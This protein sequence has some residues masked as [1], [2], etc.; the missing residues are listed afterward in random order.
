MNVN[1]P[2]EEESKGHKRNGSPSLLVACSKTCTKKQCIADQ[3]DP[4]VEIWDDS[5]GKDCPVPVKAE[6]MSRH[7]GVGIGGMSL[8]KCN[9]TPN[10]SL[11]KKA[12]FA[13]ETPKSVSRR[14]M[15]SPGDE[16]WNEAIQVA[17]GL[18]VPADE[19]ILQDKSSCVAPQGARNTSRSDSG[20][21]GAQE[22]VLDD[23]AKPIEKDIEGNEIFSTALKHNEV[24]PLPV[25]HFDFSH[26]VNNV[27]RNSSHYC[28]EEVGAV[29]GAESGLHNGS[30]RHN[31]LQTSSGLV[32][33]VA[34]TKQFSNAKPK[35]DATSL[36]TGRLGQITQ[37]GSSLAAD[38]RGGFSPRKNKTEHMQNDKILSAGLSVPAC[39]VSTVEDTSSGKS[40]ANAIH[41]EASTPSSSMPLKDQLQ[42]TSWLPS[43]VCSIYMKKGISK[44][45]SWQVCSSSLD[46][47]INRCLILYF[48]VISCYIAFP[49]TF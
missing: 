31:S 49:K 29:T 19:K 26:E 25:K 9:N 37:S 17:D 12:L 47:F 40:V 35:S 13:N 11:S 2:S 23:C 20:E 1:V 38:E 18:F 41:G 6:P 14:S 10:S 16:F 42:L 3:T 4:T 22:R 34:L 45:Y 44:L 5:S 36:S 33:N 24:S 8:R 28:S 7:S 32:G 21:L 39:R 30:L 43:E 48:V 15:F 27:V 46:P